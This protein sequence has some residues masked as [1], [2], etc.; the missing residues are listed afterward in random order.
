MKICPFCS[1][2]RLYEYEA[3]DRFQYG[4]D[5][6]GVILEATVIVQTCPD[7]MCQMSWT[8]YRGE[9]ARQAAVEKHLASKGIYL[10]GI[11]R[12][13]PVDVENGIDTCDNCVGR[14]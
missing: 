1:E 14:V 6:D 11:C 2:G 12:E 10:C 5:E 3:V 8:D 9:D 4:A 13:V 7:P